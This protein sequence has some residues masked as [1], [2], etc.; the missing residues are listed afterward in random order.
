MAYVLSKVLTKIPKT[1]ITS[2]SMIDHNRSLYQI[3][4]KL[5]GNPAH[6]RNVVCWGNHSRTV[7]PDMTYA[8]IEGKPVLSKLKD[9][10]YIEREF[11]D[12]IRNR[13][14]EIQ[15]ARNQTAG[16]STASATR[17]H[18]KAIYLGTEQG[19]WLTM[20]V[21]SD[22]K[23]YNF[24]EDIY[25]SMPVMCEKHEYEIVEGLK[26]DEFAKNQIETSIKEILTEKKEADAFMKELHE[27]KPEE[28]KK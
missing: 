25:V 19:E 27:K 13:A 21:Y 1:N 6:V 12:I 8:T 17:D 20:G 3:A 14:F 18:M 7:Y 11:L 16:F 5:G 28:A 23:V 10:A 22:G 2:L 15:K 26:W 24:P 9:K 4:K